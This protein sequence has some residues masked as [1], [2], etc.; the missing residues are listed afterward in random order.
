[1]SF[2]ENF[3]IS[4]TALNPALAIATDTSTGTDNNISQ[5]RITFT[6]STG[7]TLVVAGTSTS[8]NQWP[9]ATNPIS[10]NVLT[11][12][13]AVSVKVDWL[14]VTNVVLYSKTQS[15]C[16]AYYNK[17]FMYYLTQQESLNPSILQDTNYVSNKAKLWVSIVGAVNAVEFGADIA[18]SQNE[19]NIGTNL[20]LNENLFY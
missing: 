9:L 6:T 15:Y 17:Q 5:R 11:Q 2:S 14:D 12:D 8:Y 18:A 1:M 20:R 7:S 4:Q 13:Y 19:L 10:L 3:S 16:L